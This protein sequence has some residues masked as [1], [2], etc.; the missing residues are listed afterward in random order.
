MQEANKKCYQLKI[1]NS[2]Q[3]E[4]FIELENKEKE[5][6]EIIKILKQENSKLKENNSEL[7]KKDSDQPLLSDSNSSLSSSLSNSSKSSLLKITIKF[8][9]KNYELDVKNK[10][11]LS[12]VYD[13]FVKKYELKPNGHFL[14][15]NHEDEYPLW[16]TVGQL[17]LLGGQS[18]TLI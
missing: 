6:E 1:K 2:K 7:T 12:R 14:I 18:L 13:L 15:G 4:K 9:D 17:E 10:Y 3:E 16:T 8:K 5:Q 11:R